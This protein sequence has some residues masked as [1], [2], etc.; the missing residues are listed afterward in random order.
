[1]HL[2]FAAII[3][4]MNVWKVENLYRSHYV[5]PQNWRF[6]TAVLLPTQRNFNNT[7]HII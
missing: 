7:K 5:P 3:M 4:E 2:S 6:F 1:M